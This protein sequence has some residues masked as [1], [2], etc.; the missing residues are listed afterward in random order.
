MPQQNGVMV[1]KN[2]TLQEMA[3]TT[4]LVEVVSTT[5]YLQKRDY[6]RHLLKKITKELWKNRKSN[7][8]YFHPFGI[9]YFI[10]NTKGNLVKFDSKSDEGIFKDA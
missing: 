7:I 9:Q 5:C 4:L 3:R 1:R 10:L 2:R 6:I 8:S